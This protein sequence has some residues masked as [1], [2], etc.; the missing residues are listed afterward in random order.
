M[1]PIL[2]QMIPSVDSGTMAT[3]PPISYYYKKKLPLDTRGANKF[4]LQEEV[5]WMGK[6]TKV[7]EVVPYGMYPKAQ[8]RLRVRGYY[9]EYE[10]YVVEDS[11]GQK[12]WPR[13]G[14]LTKVEKEK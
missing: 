13:V 9:R 3:D 2:I 4:F 11:T 12:H 14:N 1:T 5:M 6:V 10:S 8:K 7:V